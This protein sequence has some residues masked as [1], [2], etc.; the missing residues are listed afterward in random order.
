MTASE[1]RKQLTSGS[2]SITGGGGNAPITAANLS[3]QIR[4]GEL[5][6]RDK[7]ISENYDPQISPKYKAQ[8]SAN[9]RIAEYPI[10]VQNAVKQYARNRE[11]EKLK[12]E[13]NAVLQPPEPMVSNKYVAPL[14]VKGLKT[15]EDVNAY[16]RANGLPETDLRV[17]DKPNFGDAF[18]ASGASGLTNFTASV[19]GLL[20]TVFGGIDLNGDGSNFVS[21]W[22]NDIRADSADLSNIAQITRQRAGGAANVI[23]QYVVE[24][25]FNAIPQAALAL[26]SGG[27]SVA[28]T[29]PS[30]TGTGIMSTIG[31]GIKTIMSSPLF[32]SA[33]GQEMG[34]AF[35]D[36]V[37]SGIDRNTAAVT[38]FITGV[39]NGSIEIGGGLE[40]LPKEVKN[41]RGWKAVYEWV[42][43]AFDEGKEEVV[44]GIVSEL[45]SK[46]TYEPNKPY[47]S[48]SQNAVVNPS[49]ALNEFVGGLSAGG[50]LGGVQT[51]LVSLGNTQTASRENVQEATDTLNA[52]NAQ[53]PET[54]RLPS[55]DNNTATAQDVVKF[56][57]DI[58]TITEQ[59][60][61]AQP[62]ATPVTPLEITQNLKKTGE[63]SAAQIDSIVKTDA[64]RKV[65]TEQTGVELPAA[66]GDARRAIRTYQTQINTQTQ[67]TEQSP[68]V[69]P[70]QAQETVQPQA[71]AQ[72]ETV[73]PTQTATET[74]VTERPTTENIPAATETDT[75]GKS[76]GAAKPN[77]R[78]TNEQLVQKYGAI[79]K[80]EAYRARD[81]KIAAESN[82]G[83]TSKFYRTAAEAEATDETMVGVI[84]GMVEDGTA[85]YVPV[86]NAK[87][88]QTAQERLTKDGYESSLG[89]IRGLFSSDKR[90]TTNDIALAE[91][92]YAEAV[93]KGDY[94]AAGEIIADISALGTEL[95][96]G[97]NAL[98]ILKKLGAPGQLATIQKIVDR[99]NAKFKG[100]KGFTEIKLS[101][102]TIDDILSQKDEKGI[103]EATIRAY[104]A[105][106]VKIPSS[107][108]DKL[109]AW[110]YFSMLANPKTHVKNMV[111]SALMLPLRVSKNTLSAV[112]QMSLPQSERTAAILNRFN[113]NDKALLDYAA[114][115]FNDVK[116]IITSSGKYNPSNAIM[117]QRKIF[118]TRFLEWARRG[119]MW[120]LEKE[121]AIFLGV[122]YKS[123]LA[124]FMKARGYTSETITETQLAEGRKVAIQEALKATF[125]DAS[126]F[127]ELIQAASHK[128]VVLN[129]IVEGIVPFK[130]T[131][132]NL[133]K[134][135]FEYSPAEF[136]RTTTR[137]IS[138][139]VKAKNGQKA[140][141]TS[142]EIVD[143]LASGLTGTMILGL[144]MW[145][146]SLGILKGIGGDD[147][148]KRNM[149]ELVGSQ[150]YSLQIDDF[151]LT[152][153]WASPSAMPLF[154]GVEMYNNL[155]GDEQT[156]AKTIGGTI[157]DVYKS[158]LNITEPVFNMSM[159]S[160]ID[161][162]I[163]S[164]AFAGNGGNAITA[165]M[166]Q[167]AS[168][169]AGQY[170]PTLGGTIARII[171]DTRRTATAPANSE[172][173]ALTS[174]INKQLAKIPFAEL[175][176]EPYIDQW[177]RSEDTGN[178]GERL[179]ENLV[180]PGYTS[181]TNVTSVDKQLY[182]L[183]DATKDNSVLPTYAGKSFTENNVDYD[184]TAEQYTKFATTRGQMAYKTLNSLFGSAAYGKLTDKQ[185]ISAVQ[186]VYNYATEEAKSGITDVERPEW[187]KA[188]IEKKLG[189][190]VA[191]VIAYRAVVADITP[192]Y[193]KDGKA[194]TGTGKTKKL[195]A[196]QSAG[197]S[198]AIASNFYDTYLS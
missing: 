40:T 79:E 41:L 67:T 96:Q 176:L 121:D 168:N 185:K 182:D 28:S 18:V 11:I 104:Q 197:M 22:A 75:F 35:N 66:I 196:L 141:Y 165:A 33:A 102:D 97:I 99:L 31:N 162:A 91:T 51:A 12:A 143:S 110:R 7:P 136:I 78:L 190:S 120:L 179:L 71:T 54:L 157:S 132:I 49:R 160:G 2:I 175:S 93:K 48:T 118:G 167:S 56:A 46:S 61:S 134:R 147:E 150:Q 170:V 65:F 32:W 98:R 155:F 124:G 191:E 39:I 126:A 24:P 20:D 19:A 4:E 152:L 151:S 94:E 77:E 128:N 140:K 13:N 133:V 189:Y 83:V 80:G 106:A 95:G 15:V 5:S 47:F 64:G 194:I 76:V 198:P 57:Q 177:G 180:L 27:A 9:T 16:K 149:D 25:V 144:G 84:K 129:V 114:N 72:S 8:A 116:D 137:K 62:V 184:M 85:S 100:K 52:I 148:K 60:A 145:L 154:V 14:S 131:P 130:K 195:K 158:L 58:S 146:T 135:G 69:V 45:V 82:A 30:V 125:R 153:D 127:A 6:L 115:D 86:S 111:G 29:L 193:D 113:A 3:K 112:M 117:E 139:M 188:A 43:S 178:I 55:L 42:K 81:V 108:V 166:L 142:A 37:S 36:A 90:I 23:G 59:Q 119:N 21:R 89:F 183:Y 163:Q 68:A 138:N 107:W 109:N 164:A 73:N 1:L 87:E 169:Y 186:K 74:A 101:Q 17:S 34:S 172:N 173:P 122:T 123:A 161:S 88:Q 103:A 105:I 181:K 192:N 92:L 174:F 171:D 26:A 70:V 38:A 159:L 63:I 50:I 156:E 10:Y 44:Q 53:L 187:E